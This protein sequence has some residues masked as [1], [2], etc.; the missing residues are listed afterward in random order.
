[1][2]ARPP[3]SIRMHT[4]SFMGRKRLHRRAEEAL[5]CQCSLP[6]CLTCLMPSASLFCVHHSGGITQHVKAAI[7]QLDVSHAV[8][9]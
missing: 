3:R 6:D 1:M 7:A 4:C 5:L 2:H 8:R 9:W